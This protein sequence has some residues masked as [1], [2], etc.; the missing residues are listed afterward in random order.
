M[1]F[2]TTI[3]NGSTG[4]YACIEGNYSKGLPR[5]PTDDEWFCK[6]C[7]KRGI[8]ET[9]IDRVGRGSSAHYLVKWMGRPTWDVS[10]EEAKTLDTAWSR[11]LI[12][13]YLGESLPARRQLSLLPVLQAPSDAHSVPMLMLLTRCWLSALVARRA[14]LVRVRSTCEGSFMCILRCGA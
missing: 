5:V 4:C 13:S 7:V 9:I 6:G 8:P 1:P 11:K 14:V 10:W 2:S 3:G 12:R